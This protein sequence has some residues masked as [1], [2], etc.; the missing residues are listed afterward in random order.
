MEKCEAHS[1]FEKSIDNLEKSDVDQWKHI[2][3]IEKSLPR[4]LPVW[5]TVVL[6]VSSALT[7]S[8]LTFAGMIIR[9]SGS[10]GS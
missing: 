1:G 2:D 10:G 3:A 7:G 6:M 9:F 5:V 8:A 4:L